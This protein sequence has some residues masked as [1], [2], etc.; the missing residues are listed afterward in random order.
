MLSCYIVLE[1]RKMMI[2]KMSVAAAFRLSNYHCD[3]SILSE[4]KTHS[5]DEYV[6][7]DRYWIWL[8]GLHL[9]PVS[10]E[11]IIFHTKKILNFLHVKHYFPE[12][13]TEIY[14]KLF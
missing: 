8:E 12:F 9:F 7:L 3:L 1:D 2:R 10:L 14:M 6:T 5:L 11:I 4:D 13:A